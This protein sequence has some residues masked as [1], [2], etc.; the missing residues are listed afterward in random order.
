MM[1]NVH[2]QMADDDDGMANGHQA[3]NDHHLITSSASSN[4]G[5]GVLA[6]HNPLIKRRCIFR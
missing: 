3:I 4:E 1:R 6:Q 2:V 5:Q